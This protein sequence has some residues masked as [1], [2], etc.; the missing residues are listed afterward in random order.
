MAIV[1]Y[2]LEEL[3]KMPDRTNWERL[4]N[5]RDEDIDYSDSPDITELLEQGLVRP[6]SRE[7]LMSILHGKREEAMCVA[8]PQ[9]K[10]GNKNETN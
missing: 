8:E 3:K 10:Y 4:R 9:A 5:M 1:S 6:V 2:T 7:Y